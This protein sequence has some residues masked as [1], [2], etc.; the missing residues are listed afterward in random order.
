MTVYKHQQPPAKHLTVYQ[1]PKQTATMG[2]RYQPVQTSDDTELVDRGADT[3]RD[4]E[5]GESVPPAYSNKPDEVAQTDDEHSPL[6]N[7][8]LK[9]RAPSAQGTNADVRAFIQLL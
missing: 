1:T 6:S 5:P 2:T 3:D 4:I 9:K 8:E 7:A